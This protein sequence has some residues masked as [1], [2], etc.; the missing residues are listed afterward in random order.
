MNRTSRNGA[1]LLA[2]SALLL[3]GC[4]QNGAASSPT[5][6]VTETVSASP[7]SSASATPAAATGS[8]SP[9][10]A[11][12]KQPGETAGL[13]TPAGDSLIEFTVKS[14]EADPS[15]TGRDPG[16][17]ETGSF[18]ALDVDLEVFPGAAE[19][20]V[21]GNLL[22]PNAFRFIGTDGETF[23]G[24]VATAPT[25]TCLPPEAL[26]NTQVADGER[27]S[28]TILLDLPED[29]GILLLEDE[30]SGNKWEWSF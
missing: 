4:G 21:D 9:R 8:S 17:P 25:F 29:S 2:V 1:L 6:T 19:N 20:Y 3:T 27:T 30:M 10:G 13:T 12:V 23:G 5:V 11:L 14:I 7:T 18:V 16:V 26:L 22:N 24:D 28:G 15:C